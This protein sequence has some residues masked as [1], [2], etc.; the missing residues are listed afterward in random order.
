MTTLCVLVYVCMSAYVSVCRVTDGWLIRNQHSS[1]VF[2]M[3]VCESVCVWLVSGETEEGQRVP[4]HLHPPPLPTLHY[5]MCSENTLTGGVCWFSLK[6]AKVSVLLCS[7][8]HS[9]PSKL[10]LLPG[11]TGGLGNMEG[12]WTKHYW[13]DG[14]IYTVTVILNHSK[15]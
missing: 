1:L 2:V 4:P 10:L 8:S 13:R 6:F 14:L 12:N 9:L 3:H 7:T 5:S 15:F 11:G